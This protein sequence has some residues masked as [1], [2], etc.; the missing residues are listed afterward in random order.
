MVQIIHYS[1][2][3]TRAFRVYTD[4]NQ[5]LQDSLLS[6]NLLKKLPLRWVYKDVI[7]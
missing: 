4:G 1:G 6:S 3:T 2:Y 5:A 7:Y